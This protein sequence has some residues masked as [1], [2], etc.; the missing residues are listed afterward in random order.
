MKQI[1]KVSLAVVSTFVMTTQSAVAEVLT[2]L[3]LHATLGI[4]TNFILDDGAVQFHGKTY[5]PVVSPHTGRV[6]LDRNIG[7]NQKCTS[8][9]DAQCYGDYFQWGRGFD[10]HQNSI[11]STIVLATDINNAGAEFIRGTFD[12]TFTDLNYGNSRATNWLKIDGSSVCPVGY[13]VPLKDELDAEVGNISNKETAYSNFLK[14]PAAG[15]RSFI[16]ANYLSIGTWGTVW[17]VSST[18]SMA[19]YFRFWSVSNWNIEGERAWGLSVRCIK[20]VGKP[21]I[22]HNTTTYATVTS[23]YTGRVWL[24]RNLGASQVCTAFDD[25]ACYGDYYQWGRGFDGHQESNSST[26]AT[27]ATDVTNVGHGD[28][29]TNNTTPNDWTSV[30]TTG[31][32]RIA[33]W[34]KTDGTSVCPVGFRVPTIDELSVELLDVGSAQIDGNTPSMD[35]RENAFSTFLKLPSSGYRYDPLGIIQSVIRG[36]LWTASVNGFLADAIAFRSDIAIQ[37][38][39]GKPRKYGNPVRCL[40]N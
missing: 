7:A 2:E 35:K 6:W 18:E 3:K 4:V 39:G 21:L 32:I 38:T 25:A 33:N 30:D 37:I 40:R 12:W 23:P 10:G 20:H 24:D 16:D 36:D 31:T 8:F 27:L 5:K 11:D 1:I 15:Y 13:R 22:Y 14:F 19:S 9:D 29:I 28:Y 17:S 34:S 26:T